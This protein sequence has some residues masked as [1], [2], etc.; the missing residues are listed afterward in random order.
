M[1]L[2]K[3]AEKKCKRVPKGNHGSLKQA[4]VHLNSSCVL[5]I[6]YCRGPEKALV[7]STRIILTRAVFTWSLYHIS[8][9]CSSLQL[10]T[11]LS[12]CVLNE[13]FFAGYLLHLLPNFYTCLFFIFLKTRNCGTKQWKNYSGPF[14]V[15]QTQSFPIWDFVTGLESSPPPPFQAASSS[16]F[17]SQLKSHFPW[18]SLL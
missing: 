12:T 8:K 6:I 5:E 1:N 3:K 9:I 2:V 17:K 7:F 10:S 11:L 13:A 18:G 4:F 16:H 15:P 14:L